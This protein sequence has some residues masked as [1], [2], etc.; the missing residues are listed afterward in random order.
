[1][2][3][4]VLLAAQ[5]TVVSASAVWKCKSDSW[6]MCDHDRHDRKF[7]NTLF[8][9]CTS[10]QCTKDSRSKEYTYYLYTRETCENGHERPA[11]MNAKVKK[12]WARLETS[13]R[14]TRSRFV[15][16]LHKRTMKELK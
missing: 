8:W 5:C 2:G 9:R 11:C 3:C 6:W 16:N 14:P 7:P 10:K 15:K 12:E 13:G 1:M 4:L